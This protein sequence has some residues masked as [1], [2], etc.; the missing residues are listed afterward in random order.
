MVDPARATRRWIPAAVVSALLLSGCVSITVGAIAP[1]PEPTTTPS[2]ASPSPSPSLGATPD[3]ETCTTR[4]STYRL[5]VGSTGSV[6]REDERV[7]RV[8]LQLARA[9]FDVRVPECEPGEV[10]ATVLDRATERF[11]AGTFVSDAPD[12]EIDVY[13]GGPT[14]ERTARSQVQLTMLHEWYHVLQF[15]FLKCDPPRC[16]VQVRPIPEWLIE[17]AAEYAAAQAAQDERLIFYSFIR[18]FELARAAEVTTP[19][20]RIRQANTG[21]EYG[22]SF[23]AVEMLVRG[24]GPGVLEG[25]WEEAGS[26]GRWDRAFSDAFGSSPARFHRAFEAYRARGFRD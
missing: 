15:S 8:A 18:R 3:P 23:A 17:G 6:S 4:L 10:V 24:S 9:H 12:F 11:A 22:L 7:V 16:Q 14:W 1:S 5:Q 13:A 20:Q 19:L 25:F 21:A 2:P 26:T